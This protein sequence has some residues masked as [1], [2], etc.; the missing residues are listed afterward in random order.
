MGREL[1]EEG[2]FHPLVLASV[3]HTKTQVQGI[4]ME[5]FFL[6]GKVHEGGHYGMNAEGETWAKG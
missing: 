6:V 5:D 4:R 2:H 3:S 1:V